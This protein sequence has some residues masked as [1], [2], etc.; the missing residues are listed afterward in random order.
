MSQDYAAAANLAAS[1]S[2]TTL[3][4]LVDDDGAHSAASP[5]EQLKLCKREELKPEGPLALKPRTTEAQQT[6]AL[7]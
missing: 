3:N 6:E 1:T 5:M 2:T 7:Q 4:N